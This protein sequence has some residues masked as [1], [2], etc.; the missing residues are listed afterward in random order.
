M[1]CGRNQQLEEAF[2]TLHFVEGTETFLSPPPSMGGGGFYGPFK[3]K[4]EH[5]GNKKVT[6]KEVIIRKWNI[7][8]YYSLNTFE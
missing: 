2:L 1:G 3:I 6:T 7:S 8:A 4:Y 5:E